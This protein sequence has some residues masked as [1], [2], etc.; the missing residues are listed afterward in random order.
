[1]NSKNFSRFKISER[2]QDGLQF[3]ESGYLFL[4]E[5]KEA[6]APYWFRA[7]SKSKAHYKEMASKLTR[8]DFC[9]GLFCAGLILSSV[10]VFLSGIC[11]LFYQ[12]VGWLQNGI[13]EKL[14]L[15][16]LFNYFFDGTALYLWFQDPG[17][18][19]GLH[20]LV[21]WTLENIP[22]SLLLIMDGIVMSTVF[23]AGILMAA[24]YRYYTLSK[25]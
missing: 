6:L 18:W 12:I 17:S 15:L 13:W 24:C 8:W 9:F 10:L 14:P 23:G 25:P 16:R 7:L 4:L 11:V 5:L 2:I 19:L 3:V 21:S 1:M 20:Q 22:I